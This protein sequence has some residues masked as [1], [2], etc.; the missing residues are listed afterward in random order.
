MKDGFS[1]FPLDLLNYKASDREIGSIR[2]SVQSQI[3]RHVSSAIATT[4][5]A[6]TVHGRRVTNA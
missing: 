3:I 1:V 5:H 2:K 4:G 6:V